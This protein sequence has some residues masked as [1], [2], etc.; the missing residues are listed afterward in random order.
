MLGSYLHLGFNGKSERGNANASQRPSLHDELHQWTAYLRQRAAV[1]LLYSFSVNGG[2]HDIFAALLNGAAL[3]PL[4]LKEQ[5]FSEL[6][7]WLIEE[8]M[9]IYHSV[10]TVFRQFAE[11]LTDQNEIPDLR[12]LRLGRRACLS[13]RIGLVQKVFF[14]GRHW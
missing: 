7:K 1:T 8:K 9:T 6:G 4:D 5:G 11:T 3:F 12:V 2:S 10:P 14:T 13:E